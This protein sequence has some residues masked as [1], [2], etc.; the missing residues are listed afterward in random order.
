MTAVP[1]IRSFA[2]LRGSDICCLCCGHTNMLL[3]SIACATQGCRALLLSK[4][5]SQNSSRGISWG[6]GCRFLGRESFASK[7]RPLPHGFHIALCLACCQLGVYNL[8]RLYCDSDFSSPHAV[9]DPTQQQTHEGIMPMP[10]VLRDCPSQLIRS[11]PLLVVYRTHDTLCFESCKHPLY[12][13]LSCSLH[14]PAGCASFG[15]A[16]DDHQSVV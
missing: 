8:R 11:M 1:E 12:I 5:L 16:P 9:L 4:T 14:T 15:L 7:Q 3:Q 6:Q 2:L 13:T 10:L